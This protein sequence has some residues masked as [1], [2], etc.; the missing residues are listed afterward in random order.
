[1]TAAACAT[2]APAPATSQSRRRLG[3]ST[4]PS[5]ATPTQPTLCSPKWDS[6][7]ATGSTPGRSLSAA[8]TATSAATSPRGAS[9][10]AASCMFGS[11]LGARPACGGQRRLPLLLAGQH[12]QRAAV[13]RAHFVEPAEQLTLTA[14]RSEQQREHLSPVPLAVDNAATVGRGDGHAVDGAQPEPARILGRHI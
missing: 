2:N 1:M 6:A 7:R 5:A 10:A 11:R 3:E 4:A 13:H 12:G 9:A 8:W 14:Q